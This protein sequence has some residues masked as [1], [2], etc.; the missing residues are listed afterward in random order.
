MKA[1]GISALV[2][3]I[4]AI[5]IP[6]IGAFLTG[7][8]GILAMIAPQRNLV[9]GLSAV[10]ISLVNVCFLSPSLILAASHEASTTSETTLTAAFYIL[11]TIQIIALVILII[12]GIR[13]RGSELA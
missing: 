8:V 5:F 6:I 10:I 1:F 7:V 2:L 9:F 11:I 3:A 4:V 13:G 12:A